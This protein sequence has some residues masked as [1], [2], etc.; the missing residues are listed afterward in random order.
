M[1]ELVAKFTATTNL[2]NFKV[3]RNSIVIVAYVELRK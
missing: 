1:A 2:Q 3:L